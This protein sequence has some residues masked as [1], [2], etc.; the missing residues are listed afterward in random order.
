ML[1]QLFCRRRARRRS[2]QR[3][4]LT[5][6]H[7]D[8]LQS[9]ESKHL[10]IDQCILT[11]LEGMDANPCVHVKQES[12][13]RTEE[14]LPPAAHLLIIA[15]VPCAC[16]E[17]RPGLL[18]GA[19]T[20]HGSAHVLR[21]VELLVRDEDDQLEGQMGRRTIGEVKLDD[22][23]HIL[24]TDLHTSC[25]RDGMVQPEE[26]PTWITTSDET[27][28]KP[29]KQTGGSSMPLIIIYY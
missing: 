4:T 14:A 8:T 28:W 19:H 21:Q 27:T 6:D 1:D 26:I 7:L 9:R 25:W 13:P 24:F 15:T 3:C 18:T 17:S 11:D 23:I 16:L 10:S 12:N 2:T 5:H 20:A 29:N 22:S